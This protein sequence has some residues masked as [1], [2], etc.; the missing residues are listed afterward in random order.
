MQISE[1]LS[2][3]RFVRTS[4]GG[5]AQVLEVALVEPDG[6]SIVNVF[7]AGEV[8]GTARCDSG[9]V[10][11]P[12]TGLAGRAPGSTEELRVEAGQGL[13]ETM[14]L[15]IAEP[16]WTVW[17]ISHF[18][19][20][21]VWWN[22][23]AA[24]TA[25]WDD[26]PGQAQEFR[27]A[28]QQT[29]FALVDAHLETARRD[30]DYK[31]VL[32]EVD[33]LKPYW[34]ARPEQRDFLR[35]LL[36]DGRLEIMGGTYNEPNT[37]LTTTETTVRN[38]V[39]GLGFQH[40]VLGG[41]PHTAWQLDVFGHDPQFPGLAAEAGLTSSSWA[42]GPHHQWGPMLS[43]PSPAAGWGDPAVMQFPAEFE[44]ISPSGKGVL[45]HYMPAHYSAGWQIDSKPTLGEAQAAVYELFTLLKRV[46]ATRNV[47]LPVGTDY[48]P[49]SKWATEIQRDWNARYSSPRFEC[50]LPKQFFAQV[51]SEL[52]DLG[53]TPAPQTRDMNPVYT[54]KDVSFIDTKQAQRRAESLLVDAEMFAAIASQY[55]A[56]YPHAALDKAW[57]QLVFGAHHDAI[58][59]SESDQVYLDLVTTWRE[60]HDIG[61]SVLRAALDHLAARLP[62]APD[63][64]VPVTV[65]NP[66]N[67]TRTDVVTVDVTPDLPARGLQV[68]APDGRVVPSVVESAVTDADGAITSAQVRF[69]ADAVPGVGHSAGWSVRTSDED[70]G[71]RT[72]P[73]GTTS[74]ENDRYLVEVDPSAGGA[75]RRLLDKAAGR[76]VVRVGAFGNE[77]VVEQEY[78]AHPEFNE[79]P[80]HL[81]PTGTVLARSTDRPATSVVTQRSPL[82]LRLV[83]S[84]RLADATYVQTITLRA[85]TDRVECRTTLDGFTGADQLVR[86]CWAADVP[87]ALPASDV[88][89]AVVGRGFGFRNSDVAEHPWTLDNPA[90][91]WFALTST[92]RVRVSPPDGAHVERAI[93]IAELVAADLDAAGTLRPLAVALA[94]QGVT[95][96]TSVGAGSRYG[97]LAIDSNLPD[98][99]IAIGGPDENPFTALVLDNADEQYR[100]EID[101]QLAGSGTARVWVPA[102]RAL[103]DVWQP[104]ADLSGVR[105]LPVLVVI[106]AGEVDALIDDLADATIDVN[107]SADAAASREPAL[108]D[109]TVA[110]VN[111]GMPSFNVGSDGTLTT[112]VLRSCTGWP[113]GVWIDPPRRTAPDGSNFQ[114]QHW[115][116]HFE[117]E[118]VAGAGDW[119]RN[120]LVRTGHEVN[121]PLRSSQAAP[122]AGA[123]ARDRYLGVDGAD[124]VV[125]AVKASGNPLAEGRAPGPV[126]GLTVRLIEPLGTTQHGTLSTAFPTD[127]VHEL[128]LVERERAVVAG[129]IALTPMQVATVRVGVTAAEAEAEAVLVEERDPHQPT[130]SRYWLDNTGPAPIGDMPV[131]V[132]AEPSVVERAPGASDP[133]DLT[134][135][136]SSDRTDA[137]VDTE[138][139][140]LVPPG[141]TAEP[142]RV[143][144]S[145]PPGGHHRASV[146]VQP[147]ADAEAGIWWV[148]SRIES[149][150]QSVEDVTRVLLGAVDPPEVEVELVGPDPLVTGQDDRIVAAVTNHARSAVS[151]RVQLISPWHTWELVDTWDTG[152]TVEPGDTARVTFAVHARA[153]AE[154]GS[155]WALAKVAVAGAL[156]YT[157]PVELTVR[158]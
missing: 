108:D 55:G 23:Q 68:V 7:S 99:R 101:K 42:R 57:R 154:T 91:N 15:T 53:R 104:S 25:V 141:W 100:I 48:T 1:I 155:W 114:Q 143:P 76:E 14:Q 10:E 132:H 120:G 24:Y 34:D 66:S 124:V 18:H 106:G 59:G 147:A 87:G 140:V 129:A 45:T 122:A 27:Q 81:V 107:Q 137:T 139:E 150:G 29:G 19:Y 56:R 30:P 40:G 49:P 74:I 98:V 79:G 5:E 44:W 90:V 58:T 152:V 116:H 47:L 151:A 94:G 80:W 2:T 16:G 17:M 110:L 26:L 35:R 75:V 136:V 62:G 112:A 130:Y 128:D 60:A 20:D 13:V 54:G 36:A 61:R 69:L 41:D 28:F 77:L 145:L 119:R 78:P 92:A 89:S 22:T 39:H 32:A 93:G 144:V 82:G 88:G 111:T 149:G 117:Y 21:P 148:R 113:S 153:A 33:Y 72:E 4:D 109:Y 84:G 133:F 125:S 123:P 126:E 142:A 73:D 118:L 46:A 70:T 11:V 64:G 138:V 83:V 65:F 52:A 97:K 102:G 67:W 131:T 6:H 103:V 95:A 158:S 37:N 86:V 134:V 157:E 127:G 115:T 50:A 135:M 71:W 146:R 31:F 38:F 8:V 51:R 156:H 121:H 12:L 96:T 63:T 9:R 43:Q 105:D 85:G 3:E